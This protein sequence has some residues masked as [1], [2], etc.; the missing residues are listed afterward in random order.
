MT[1]THDAHGN[2][3]KEV[4]SLTPRGGGNVQHVAE[5]VVHFSDV[6]FR[7]S[8]SG[9]RYRRIR[10]GGKRAVCA[11]MR[12]TLD[13]VAEI[14]GDPF[15]F[16]DSPEWVRVSFNPKESDLLFHIKEN[17]VRGDEVHAAPEAVYVASA[18][19]DNPTK[20]RVY[21]KRTN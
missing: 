17:G 16:E 13:D 3:L 7:V 19:F 18:A 14:A 4:I 6:T 21:I 2:I 10:N 1:W 15:R 9:E 11:W 5:S 12:G 8:T 20:T